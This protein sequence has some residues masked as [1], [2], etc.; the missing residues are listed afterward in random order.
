MLHL[1]WGQ[2]VQKVPGSTALL[3]ICVCVTDLA[4][5]GVERNYVPRN[6]GER[7]NPMRAAKTLS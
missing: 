1:P 2:S 5:K 4:G 6:H 7:V 3:N